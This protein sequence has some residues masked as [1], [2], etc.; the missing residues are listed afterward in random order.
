MSFIGRTFRGITG[1]LSRPP[2]AAFTN[3]Y[4]WNGFSGLSF[5]GIQV[6]PEI[7]LTFSAV[8]ACIRLISD[9]VASM[10][11]DVLQRYP[12]GR[13]QR[14]SPTF[15]LNPNPE[16][17]WQSFVQQLVVSR[18]LDGN[19]YFIPIYRGGRCV[20]LWP[21]EPRSV[22]IQRD[23]DTLTLRYFVHG[24]PLTPDQ[25]VHIRGLTIPGYLKGLS[26]VECARHTIGLALSA[27]KHGSK[28]FAQGANFDTV[29]KVKQKL[30][31]EDAKALAMGFARDHSG[32]DNAFLPVVLDND[33]DITKLSMTAE[34][35]QFLSARQFQVEE[36]CRWYGVPPHKIAQVEKTTSWGAGVEEQ[37]IGFSQDCIQP[38]LVRL[39][40]A[41]DP[42]V[43]LENPDFY[44]RFN[45]ASLLRG[46]MTARKEFYTAM[47]GIG[48]FSPD[49]VLGLEDM[50]PVSGGL[51]KDHYIPSNFVPIGAPVAA[52][53][54]A[55]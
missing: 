37:N 41:L 53:G 15:L 50:N 54:V 40:A 49:D 30:R 11:L 10:P 21:L 28:M 39:E 24:T 25:I 23:L 38:E 32:G 22:T 43:K 51:G 2:D 47:V 36:V 27:E 13:Y 35:A 42:L 45:M 34:E 48:A 55:Q 9:I 3:S 46:N 52:G 29:I 18:L 19:A 7:A 31:R 14:P 1:G 16:M 17:T 26:P 33:A 44:T 5:S 8:F 12:T 6:T 4:G 20:E